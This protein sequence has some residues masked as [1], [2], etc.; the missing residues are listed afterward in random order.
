M[1][2]FTGTDRLMHFL[3]DAYEDSTHRYH[4]EFIEHF[5]KIDDAVGQMISQ[6]GDDDL[7]VMHSDHGF[8]R[9]DSD[10]N[11]NFVLKEH[12]FLKFQDNEEVTLK[13]ISSDTKV[14]ALDPG[15]IYLNFAGRYPGGT[16]L[17]QEADGILSELE[18]LFDSLEVD[19][20]KVIR[21][22]YRKEEIYS[23][24]CVEDAA[25]MILVGDRNFNLRGNIKAQSLAEKGVF[26][27][28]HTQDDA[29]LLVRDGKGDCIFP[30]EPCISDILSII[31]VNEVAI[32]TIN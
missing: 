6:L 32:S 23:G 25:D 14:F 11:V 31:R 8:E 20:R 17:P 13:N 21:K 22:V 26:T 2:V 5:R 1:V 28:K 10:I 12:G 7:V 29:F 9:L 24:P 3:W 18:E 16:V 4:N 19:G 15:R 27:G 30:D